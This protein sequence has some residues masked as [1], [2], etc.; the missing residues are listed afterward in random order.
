VETREELV[1]GDTIQLTKI[2]TRAVADSC[3]PL[4]ALG[5]HLPGRAAGVACGP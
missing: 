3:M 4:S 5:F 2:L 1:S